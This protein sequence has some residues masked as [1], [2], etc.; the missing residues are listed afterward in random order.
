[1]VRL[2]DVA[3]RA[4]S[5]TVVLIVA[6]R[7]AGAQRSVLDRM[8]LDKLQIVSLGVSA[9]TIFP[10][11]LE[12]AKVFALA[13]DY[14]EFAPTWR[15]LGNASFWRSRYRAAVVGAFVDSLNSHLAGTGSAKVVASP[16]SVYDATFGAGARYTP[17]FSGEIKPFVEIGI[18]AHVINAEG[19]LINGTFIERSLDNIAT[20]VYVSCGLS[21][22]LVS[23]LGVEATARGDLLSGY[24]SAQVRAGATYFFGHIRPNAPVGGGTP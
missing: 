14:G 15:L 5:S 16:I 12:T 1:M 4:L 24:R 22:K 7:Y 18:A 19:T 17:R 2:R 11:Q 3:L 21:L 9:G 10:S 20:G 23:H 6:A 8:G 13:A